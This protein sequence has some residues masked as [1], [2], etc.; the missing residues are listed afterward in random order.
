MFRNVYHHTWSPKIPAFADGI[1]ILRR[2]GGKREKC[3]GPNG[4]V[5]VML[6]CSFPTISR[7]AP[8]WRELSKPFSQI[9]RK[10]PMTP[11]GIL[12]MRGRRLWG[13]LIQNV[14]H[15][16]IKVR[17]PCFVIP[18]HSNPVLNNLYTSSAAPDVIGYIANV[19]G[20]T[21][22]SDHQGRQAASY[23]FAWTLPTR[24]TSS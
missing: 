19:G 24:T 16:L 4:N 11:Q 13:F 10:A 12:K 1:A 22:M 7:Q 9:W 17:N 8:Q 6:C 5:P 18:C 14:Y 15:R 20:V 21:A 3:S 23:I 2:H